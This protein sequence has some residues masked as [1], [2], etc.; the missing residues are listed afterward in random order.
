ML[1]FKVEMGNQSVEILDSFRNFLQDLLFSLLGEVI[2][3]SIDISLVAEKEGANQTV[4]AL[5]G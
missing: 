3:F 1:I 5:E 2:N 4:V